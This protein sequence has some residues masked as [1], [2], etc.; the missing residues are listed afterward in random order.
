[1]TVDGRRGLAGLTLLCFCEFSLRSLAPP[2]L[3][4]VGTPGSRIRGHLPHEAPSWPGSLGVFP[5][6]LSFSHFAACGEVR[7]SDR[8]GPA[9]GHKPGAVNIIPQG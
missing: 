4:S 7:G 2:G 6:G 5:T 9:V 3:K 8:P 1:M